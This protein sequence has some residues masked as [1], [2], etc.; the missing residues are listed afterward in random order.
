MEHAQEGVLLNVERV[1]VVVGSGC[2]TIEKNCSSQLALGLGHCDVEA[3]L[4]FYW[5]GEVRV[6]QL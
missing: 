6:V 3:C 4:L 1:Q 5:V 2:C